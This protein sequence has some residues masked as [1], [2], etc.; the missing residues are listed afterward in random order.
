MSA[1]ARIILDSIIKCHVITRYGVVLSLLASPLGSPSDRY[2]EVC[3][4]ACMSVH[5]CVALC[6]C[7]SRAGL[8]EASRD[9]GGRVWCRSAEM[10][11]T[12]LRDGIGIKFPT[13]GED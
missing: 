13:C 12:E 3:V 7:V 4:F 6:V 1:K 5:V 11:W 9:R 2:G 10:G 8:T